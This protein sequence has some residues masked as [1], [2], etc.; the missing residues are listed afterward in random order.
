V[1]T[2][3]IFISKNGEKIPTN[4]SSFSFFHSL[5]EKITK[6]RIFGTEKTLLKM[7]VYDAS[8]ES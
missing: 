3:I 1:A 4:H 7:L 5:I 8:S 6:L 2:L